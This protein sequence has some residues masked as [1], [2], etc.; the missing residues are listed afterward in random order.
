[1][2]EEEGEEKE[3]EEEKAEDEA[4][5]E[6]QE[7]EE[8]DGEE[9]ECDACHGEGCYD[10]FDMPAGEIAR[11]ECVPIDKNEEESVPEQP[12]TTT[13]TTAPRSTLQTIIMD[14]DTSASTILRTD[15]AT[16]FLRIAYDRG[17]VKKSVEKSAAKV[18]KEAAGYKNL[19]KR[20]GTWFMTLV[21]LAEK[22]IKPA[23]N[24]SGDADRFAEARAWFLEQWS[25]TMQHY[26]VSDCAACPCNPSIRMPKR[27]IRS[28]TWTLTPRRASTYTR[29][30]RC[31]SR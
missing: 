5:G 20:L 25:H 18:C 19:P 13:S 28:S 14:Q 22:K 9:D 1:M 17:H 30:S 7:E 16:R 11:D 12:K 4:D 8:E 27:A 21:I 26:S 6:E 31:W 29:S 2:E 10:C 3:E 23:S 15:P 24:E